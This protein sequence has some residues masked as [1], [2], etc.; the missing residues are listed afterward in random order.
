MM[1]QDNVEAHHQD[2]FIKEK[3]SILNNIYDLVIVAAKKLE[4]PTETVFQTADEKKRASN[5]VSKIKNDQDASNIKNRVSYIF[6][7]YQEYPTILDPIL[8]EVVEP[9]MKFM[10]LYTKKACK[11]NNHEIPNEV[12]Q[13]FEIL[14]NLASVRGHKTLVKFFPH[15]AADMEPCVELLH[16]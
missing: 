14:Y 7:K 12:S 6:M 11:E 1:D 5:L 8:G 10:Q 16:F 13:L 15:E 9:I 2:T 3:H 4:I